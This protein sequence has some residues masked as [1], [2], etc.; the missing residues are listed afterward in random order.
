MEFVDSR[1][2]F[3]GELD[4]FEF[5]ELDSRVPFLGGTV[6]RTVGLSRRD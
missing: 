1:V 2:P 6:G 5:D 4:A 3:L